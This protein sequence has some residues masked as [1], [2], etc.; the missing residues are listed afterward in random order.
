MVKKIS[1]A[2]FWV[3]FILAVA[4]IFPKLGT[5]N[6]MVDDTGCLECHDASFP[7]GTLHSISSHSNCG[8]CHDGSPGMGN[9]AS[10]SCIVCHPLG[11]PG[12]CELVLFHEDSMDY[13]P[14]GASCIVCHADCEGGETTTTTTVNGETTTTTTVLQSTIKG[15][16][17]EVFLVGPFKEGCSA[18]TMTFRSDNV[19]I[20]QCMD[21]FGT[22]FSFGNF[23]TAFY[24]S[25]NYY[26][27]YGLVLLLTGFASDSYINCGGIAYF[28]N[29]I[30]PV[31]LTGYILST[32]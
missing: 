15:N 19:L 21:G 32:P 2:I 22:Y 12:K 13:D 28:G 7:G 24:W 26:K 6:L 23:F 30:S 1:I 16:R 4:F 3:S 31:A 20:L 17:Y 27:G 29:N 14:S 10:S 25:N 5:S 8:S 18:T 9:V 11:E